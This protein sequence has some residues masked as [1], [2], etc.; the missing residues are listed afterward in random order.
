MKNTFLAFCLIF[1]STLLAQNFD[2]LRLADT[3][4]PNGY[5]LTDDSKCISIQACTFFKNPGMYSALI[6][7]I[8]SKDIQNFEHK[9]D[10]GSIMYF[11]FENDFEQQGFLEG[12]LWGG[13]KPTKEHP[14]E[15]FTYKNT[16]I[17]WSF[18][19]NSALKKISKSKIEKTLK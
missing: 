12:L 4:I 9:N 1:A 17:I 7:K 19:A 5:Q 15:F 2:A 8:K 14:E 6:G 3:E 11:E 10:S 18:S 16:L 13:K